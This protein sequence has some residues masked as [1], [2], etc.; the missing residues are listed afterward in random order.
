MKKLLFLSIL[1][2][3]LIGYSL[4]A[5]GVKPLS[6]S[7][8]AGEINDSGHDHSGHDHAE[9]E[10][11]IADLF[12]D[13][14]HAEDDHADHG[15]EGH[16]HARKPSEGHDGHNHGS[17]GGLCV[18]H[19]VNEADCA[20]C[21]GS[22]LA[23]L[24]PGHGMKVRLASPDVAAKAGVSIVQPQRVMLANG[25]ELPGQ[26]AYNR[27]HLAYLTSLA[28]G[29]VRKVHV[30]PGDHIDKGDLLVDIAMPEV[31]T[32]KAEYFSAKARQV[33]AKFTYQREKDLLQRG[34]TSRQEFQQ[35]EAEYLASRSATEQFRHQLLNFGLTEG[36]IEQLSQSRHAGANVSLTSPFAGEV[37]DLQTAVGEAVSAGTALVTVANLDTL[38]IE[39]AIPESRIYQAHVGAAIEARFDG[40]PDKLFHGELFQIGAAIDE[41]TRTLKALAAVENPQ[42]RL[43]VGMFG[44]VRILAGAVSDHLAVPADAVQNIDGQ[45]YLFIQEEPDLFELRRVDV[46][47][48]RNG[49]VVIST[50]LNQYDQVVAGQGFALKSEVLKARLGAS[51]ADH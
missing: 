31:A 2:I 8:A 44:S 19:N 49:L 24:A 20:L 7:F 23:D 15:H 41:R 42:H 37:T 26:V 51:C 4:I 1:F 40:L 28:P 18:E 3:A 12:E 29:V 47:T 6:Q 27:K 21:Q 11:D 17:L 46:G 22:H 32:L 48:D 10:Q 25:S 9:P 34:I 30:Q 5:I 39:L 36:D 38:W 33:Q 35:A 45:P 13:D 14:E 43:K 16:D 50:G